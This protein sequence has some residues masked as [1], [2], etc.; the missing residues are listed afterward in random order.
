[1]A[2]AAARHLADGVVDDAFAFADDEHEERTSGPDDPVVGIVMGS[3]HPWSWSRRRWRSREFDVPYEAHVRRR[4]P[5]AALGRLHYAEAAAGRGLRGA[6]A[7][8]CRSGAPPWG[9][10]PPPRRCRLLASRA[11]W[12][13]AHGLDSPLLIGA[14]PPAGC[15]WRRRTS[16]VGATP[17]ARCPHL[18]APTMRSATRWPASRRSWPMGRGPGHA[19]LQ[20][21]PS[22]RTPRPRPAATGAAAPTGHGLCRSEEHHAIRE[23]VRDIAERDIA[24][25]AADV[26]AQLAIWSR[27]QGPHGQPASTPP[28]SPGDGGGRRRDR[29][30][31]RY[32]E[33]VAARAPLQLLPDP[34]GQQVGSM[35]II[36][37]ASQ[38]ATRLCCRLWPG[39][40][41]ISY[42]L[43]SG[44]PA[45]MW[46]R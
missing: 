29:D 35:P 3:D 8:G 21:G 13:M 40:A 27:R 28:T 5:D 42:G 25:H 46:W 30:G 24:P 19:A 22:A 7:G 15:G 38:D 37:L 1:M 26:D 23:V 44:R 36:L 41:M 12:R 14:Q 43:R 17:A 9:W 10:S 33:E 34:G 31:H 11:R 39:E 20:D 32:I 18:A 2:V 45:S 16:T 4:T 6:I